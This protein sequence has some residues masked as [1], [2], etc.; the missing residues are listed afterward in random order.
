MDSQRGGL[1]YHQDE[2]ETSPLIL[3]PIPL[4]DNH[5]AL[6]KHHT[7]THHSDSTLDMKTG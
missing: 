6:T 1:S 7:Q 5:D 3:P 4:K 2:C